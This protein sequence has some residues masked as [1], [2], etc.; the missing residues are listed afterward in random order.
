M[1]TNP[2]NGLTRRKLLTA[3]AAT[4]AAGVA[5]TAKAVTINGVPQ[6]LPFDHNG[7]LHYEAKGWQFFTLEEAREVEAIVERLIPADDLSA[8]GKEA[9]CAVFIDRQLASHY[10]RYERLYQHGPFVPGVEPPSDLVPAERYRVGIEQLGRHCQATFG[11]RFSELE[12]DQRDEVL[13]KMESGD[14]AFEG[15][16]SEVFFEQILQNAMEG[17]FADPIY[18]GNRD[19][20][21]W[22][23]LGFPGARYDYRPYIDR[24]NEKLDLIPL[25]IIGSSSWSRKG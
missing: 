6:W 8:S 19:M 25:S 16:E 9:G 3:S 12:G 17:F 18:G 21:S 24:H 13:R 4:V 14:I 7:P 10:G 23:M 5:A 22:K 2:P 15:I 20:V 11:K 1:P